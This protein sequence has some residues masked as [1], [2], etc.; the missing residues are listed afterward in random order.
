MITSF[1]TDPALGARIL[2]DEQVYTLVDSQPYTRKLG[3]GPSLLL[4]WETTC[5]E[6]GC[7]EQFRVT[8]GRT[9]AWLQRRCDAHK[10]GARAVKGRRSRKVRVRVESA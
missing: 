1:T 3:G 2:L 4:T 5:P 6:V 10:R 8:S 9:I 7:G